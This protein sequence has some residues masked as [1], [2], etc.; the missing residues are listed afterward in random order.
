MMMEA[1]KLAVMESSRGTFSIETHEVSKVEDG[2]CLIKIELSGICATDVHHWSTAQEGPIVYGHEFCGR[3]VKLG[4]GCSIDFL[5]RK[6]EVG[7]RV[8]VKPGMRCGTCYWCTT[9][10]VPSKCENKSTF[11]V[12]K[13]PWFT[14]G[15]AEYMYLPSSDGVVFKTES[16][17]EAACLLEPLSCAVNEVMTAKQEIGDTVVVQGTGPL[18]L[19]TIA[20]ARFYGAGKIIAVGGPEYRLQLARELGADVT[21]NIHD[22]KNPEERVKHV[23]DETISCRGADVVYECAGVPQAVSEGL[24]YLRHGGTYLEAGNCSDGGEILINPFR[25]I[26]SKV[27][28]I[29]TAWGSGTEHFVRAM[30]IIESGR[31]PLDMLI[32][33]KV[34][35]SRLDEAFECIAT[36]YMLDGR[37]AVKIVLDPRL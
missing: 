31:F 6:L 37:E 5:G 1:G 7:D 4:N 11:G 24:E 30:S 2:A 34:P 20:C 32:T 10:K 26:C 36:D 17:A 23:L 12:Y 29:A 27:I 21:I 35:F 3:I 28:R 33:H 8:A 14:A 18:G 22:I 15:H 9:G 19:L 13:E 16:S 25:Q